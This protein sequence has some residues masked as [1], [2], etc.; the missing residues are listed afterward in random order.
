MRERDASVAVDVTCPPEA[1]ATAAGIVAGLS[2]S[3]L[4]LAL[5]PVLMPTGYS[6]VSHTTSE[7]AAQG[8]AG[9][10]LARCGSLLFGFSVSGWPAVLASVLL[11]LGMAALPVAAG[12]LQRGMFAVAY[13]WYAT[14][15][16]RGSR[17]GPAPGR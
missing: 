17:P 1:R 14:E 11:P 9:A 15:A 3:A 16:V 5:A 13:A 12:A 10:W 2:A 8:V 4:I 7:S 6:W